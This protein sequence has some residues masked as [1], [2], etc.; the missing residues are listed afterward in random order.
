MMYNDISNNEKKMVEASQYKHMALACI[1]CSAYKESRKYSLASFKL[2]LDKSLIG[3][4]LLSFMPQLFTVLRE[5]RKNILYKK[6]NK[7]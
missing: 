4:Y 5:I 1:L 2:K 7:R 6:G 3:W